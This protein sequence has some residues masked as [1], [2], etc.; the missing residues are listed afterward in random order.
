VRD[1]RPGM[2]YGE[3]LEMIKQRRHPNVDPAPPIELDCAH[4]F[5]WLEKTV[6]ARRNDLG[7][8]I[9]VTFRCASCDAELGTMEKQLKA[10]TK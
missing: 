6:A 7:L 10:K 2:T 8:L 5:D 1:Y 4:P 9:T 3:F